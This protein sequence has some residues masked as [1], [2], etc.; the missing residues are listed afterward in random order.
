M[1]IHTSKNSLI[2][3]LSTHR[4]AALQANKTLSV[5]FVPTMGALHPGHLTLVQT[6]LEENDLVVVSIFV[7]PTQF[8]NSVDLEKYPRN[9]KKDIAELEKIPG[10]II[11]FLPEVSDLYG[12]TP[13]SDKYDFKGLDQVMEG[14]HRAGHFNGVGTVL[15]KFF[16]IINPDK[17]YFG[18]KDYQQLQIVKRLVEIEN[19]PIQIVGCPILRENNG[20][21][22]SSRNERLSA[23]QFNEAAIIHKILTEVQEKFSSH[24]IAQLHQFVVERFLTNQGIELEYFEIVNEATL[25]SINEK[26]PAVRYRAFIAAFVGEVRLIDNI[27][28]N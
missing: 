3:A 20:L 16:R 10:E 14:E 4:I 19:L 24:S 21:A 8:N 26:N 28:L 2:K 1:V 11:V 7:N 9:P 6:A 17:A 27:S 12:N 5:G 23:A 13:I 25:M 18:E 15:N 22:M